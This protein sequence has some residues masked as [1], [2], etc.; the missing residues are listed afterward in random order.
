MRLADISASDAF[1]A[2]AGKPAAALADVA[3]TINTSASASTTPSPGAEEPPPAVSPR[4]LFLPVRTAIAVKST[5][6]SGKPIPAEL[7]E[8]HVGTPSGAADRAALARADD[9]RLLLTYHP[10]EAG[11]HTLQLRFRGSAVGPPRPLPVRPGV[12]QQRPWARVAE[13]EREALLAWLSRR[14]RAAAG[15]RSTH[16][17]LCA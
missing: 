13:P 8:A 3:S 9:G 15:L 16:P 6:A 11:E 17:H 10:K 12:P 2:L 1:S 5:T 4:F 14:L 7:F